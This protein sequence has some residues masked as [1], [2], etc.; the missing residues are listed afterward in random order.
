MDTRI[1]LRNLSEFFISM[2]GSGTTTLIKKV[3]SE[4][5]VYVLVPNEQMA[6]EFGENA[7]TFEGLDKVRGLKPKPILLDN[8]TLRQLSE[9]SLN[10]Y[11]DLD[12]K[13]KTRNM[14]LRD[15]KH[16]I[17]IFERVNGKLEL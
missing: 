12:S 10:E 13:I 17:D 6:K 7:I 1:L 8:Y 16:L 11:N 4:N 5:D 9:L 15:I 3:A 14:L 2:R